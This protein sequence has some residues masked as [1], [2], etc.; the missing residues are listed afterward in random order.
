MEILTKE[1][2]MDKLKLSNLE[3]VAGDGWATSVLSFENEEL[4]TYKRSIRQQISLELLVSVV[5]EID[6]KEYILHN[7]ERA[8]EHI[9]E[10]LYGVIKRRLSRIKH[11]INYG[12]KEETSFLVDRLI[13][14][15]G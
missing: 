5:T 8:A 2:I 12:D 15:L 7:K 4:I 11:A 9:S 13:S 6:K 1:N 14:D 3:E 10:E